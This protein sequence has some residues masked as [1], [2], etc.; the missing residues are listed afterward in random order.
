MIMRGNRSIYIS[1]FENEVHSIPKTVERKGRSE[2]LILKRNELLICRYYYCVKIL[3][4]QYHVAIIKLENEF[5]ISQR[6][7]IDMISKNDGILKTFL[8]TKPTV[9][10][11]RDRYPFMAWN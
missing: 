8:I 3:N 10:Y 7:I 9:K 11:F 1:L 4:L 5:F 2:A 6:T